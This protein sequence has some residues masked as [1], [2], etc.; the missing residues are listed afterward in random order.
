G[1][2]TTIKPLLTRFL[3]CDRS[4]P[5][6]ESP[7]AP[8]SPLFSTEQHNKLNLAYTPVPAGTFSARCGCTLAPA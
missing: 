4:F 3:E 6:P 2:R 8:D 7:V 5:T 1:D